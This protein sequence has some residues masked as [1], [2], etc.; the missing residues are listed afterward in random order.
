VWKKVKSHILDTNANENALTKARCRQKV[1][2]AGR[3]EN[4]IG[5]GNLERDSTKET[6]NTGKRGFWSNP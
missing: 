1:K 4:L 6:E 3:Q 5:K 2:V